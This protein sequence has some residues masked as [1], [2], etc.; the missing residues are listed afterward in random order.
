MIRIPHILPLLTIALVFT[1]CR[2]K[3]LLVDVPQLE[4]QVVVSSQIIPNAAMVIGLTRSFGA[5]EEGGSDDIDVTDSLVSR[6]LVDGATVT[7]SYSG[8]TDTLI[9]LADG[10]Y[11]SVPLLNSKTPLTFWKLTTR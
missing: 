1:Q 8:Q 7:I 4:P 5:L 6:L 2:P 9:Q 10:L 11:V 3:P